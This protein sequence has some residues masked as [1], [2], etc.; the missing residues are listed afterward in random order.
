M[1]S[2]SRTVS[3]EAA[4]TLR[5]QAR[6]TRQ[7]RL[8][9]PKPRAAKAAISSSTL[10]RPCSSNS[11]ERI[12][13]AWAS[14]SGRSGTAVARPIRWERVA[15]R[16]TRRN[17]PMVT[18]RGGGGAGSAARGGAGPGGGEP[19]VGGRRGGG[20]ARDPVAHRRVGEEAQEL[21]HLLGRRVGGR[22]GLGE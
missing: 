7:N 8:W 1:L 14:S 3:S 22:R 15:P 5:R 10:T 12:S 11:S 19:R 13:Q 9:A 17:W 6:V 2:R 4:M 18:D 16:R 20:P 21:A